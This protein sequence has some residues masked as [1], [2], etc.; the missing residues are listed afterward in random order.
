MLAVS[1]SAWATSNAL[2]PPNTALATVSASPSLARCTPVTVTVYDCAACCEVCERHGAAGDH[3]RAAQREAG[4]RVARE[5]RRARHLGRRVEVDDSVPT[6]VELAPVTSNAGA[7]VERRSRRA[8]RDVIAGARDVRD[9]DGV[10]RRALRR[11]RQR[12]GAS[13]QRRAAGQRQARD[14]VVRERPSRAAESGGPSNITCTDVLLVDTALATLNDAW[15]RR[16]ALHTKP[17]LQSCGPAALLRDAAEIGARERELRSA[18]GGD[19]ARARGARVVD[20][21]EIGAIAVLIAPCTCDRR[22]SSGRTCTPARPARRAG[23]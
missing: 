10:R 12:D 17:R 13:R 11:G 6:P 7:A 19:R 8:E 23:R 14:R 1:G 9:R 20:A 15:H 16:S 21:R 18:V 5:R 22:S 4:D 2:R 3:G